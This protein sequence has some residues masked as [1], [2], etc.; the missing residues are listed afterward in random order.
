MNKYYAGAGKKAVKDNALNM[1]QKYPEKARARR[2]VYRAVKEG[3]LDKP[4]TCQ[5]CNMGGRIEGHH[6][7]YS[8]P[9][10]VVWLCTGCHANYHE[11]K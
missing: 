2:S 9:L 10:E 11:V 5:G 3:R 8:K 1:L 6:M 7:N 4:P